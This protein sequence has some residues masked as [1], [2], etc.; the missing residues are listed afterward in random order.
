[1]STQLGVPRPSLASLLVAQ[2]KNGRSIGSATAFIVERST[3]RYLVT[4]RHVIRGEQP[5]D[6]PVLPDELVVMQHV[7]GPVGRLTWMPRTEKL[8][9]EGEPR[10]Y[11]H[12]SRPLEIDVAALPLATD[13]G[14]DVYTYDLWAA[15]RM[16]S[17]RV[18]EELHIIGFPFGETGGG[19]LG[20][21]VRGFIATDIE[22]DWN[23]LP[24]FLV[25]SRT[26]PG[27]S[28]SPVVAFSPAGAP[29]HMASGGV[30]FLDHD[31]EEFFGVYSGRINAESDL[32]I[33]WNSQVV[34]EIIEAAKAAT[35]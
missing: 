24:R 19:A 14:I 27:Q 10:W 6:L 16:L 8:Y 17:V 26:R 25:D 2:R 31:L 13:V 12:P 5:N 18:S 4:N 21:W 32:G 9:A 28:G 3:K 11:E 33:V 15:N 20:I 7:P 23:G 22:M 35:L 29:T 1:M 34:R 30:Q